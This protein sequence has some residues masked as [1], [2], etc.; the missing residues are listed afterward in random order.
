MS[1]FTPNPPVNT[2][3][4]LLE[5]LISAGSLTARLE[6]L[7][8]RQLRVEVVQ[9]ALCPLT[10]HQKQQLGIA[11]H[12]RQLAWVRT[13][14]LYGDE[15]E[16]WVRAVSI[17]PLTS[18]AGD[19]RRLAHLGSTPIGYVLFKKQ[20]RIAHTRRFY[21]ENHRHF[22]RVS[23]YHSFGRKIGIDECFLP[24]FLAHLEQLSQR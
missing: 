19:W 17:F 10:H 16:A 21:Q 4:L 22:G 24:A 13:V 6:A 12:R 8:G 20:R 7:A 18:L 11:Q 15:G 1:V 14:L 5:H 9:S 3:P 2:P 23:I